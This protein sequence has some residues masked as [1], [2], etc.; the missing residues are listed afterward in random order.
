MDEHEH[1]G[2]GQ[3]MNAADVAAIIAERDRLRAAFDRIAL[4]PAEY[5]H[6]LGHIADCDH[7][8]DQCRQLAW[9]ALDGGVDAQER[10][11][12][13]LAERDRLRAVVE[14]AHDHVGV[15]EHVLRSLA[16]GDL[17]ALV[18]VLRQDC[19]DAMIENDRLRAAARDLVAAAKAWRNML[20]IRPLPAH[21]QRVVQAFADA[22]DAFDPMLS[23][24]TEPLDVS[25]DMG[26]DS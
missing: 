8:C 23:E 6:A 22:V 20:I 14:R 18:G 16:T 3:P 9:Q 21:R 17:V 2:P 26:G 24:T 4:D 15:D 19:R 13:I 11:T 5:R 25:A 10:A 1:Y 7:N 12:D